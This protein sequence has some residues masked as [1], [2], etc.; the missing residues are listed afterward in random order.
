[1]DIIK[2]SGTLDIK[3]ERGSYGKFY[4]FIRSTGR[5]DRIINVS[6]RCI[7]FMKEKV[8]NID[9]KI[10]LKKKKTFDK[11]LGTYNKVDIVKFPKNQEMYVSIYYQEEGEIPIDHNRTV[12]LNPDEWRQL[13]TKVLKI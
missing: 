3:E 2:L 7:S 11:I 8:V 1:M 4:R 13:R 9:K 6:C 12:N 10:K 5:K